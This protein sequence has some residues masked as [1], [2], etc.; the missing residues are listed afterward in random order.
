MEW[1][2]LA[3]SAVLVGVVLMGAAGCGKSKPALED[4]NGTP[5][6]YSV[7]VTGSWPSTQ[8]VDTPV[9][10][11]LRAENIGS[12]LPHLVIVFDGLTPTWKVLSAKGCGQKGIALQP[13]GADPGWDFG[14]MQKKQI[15]DF[16]F[17]VVAQTAAQSAANVYVRLFGAALN[18]KVGVKVPVNGGM[19]LIGNVIP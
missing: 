15:C 1:N 5:M 19:Q 8:E 13:L 16:V 9:D 10:L 18:G 17:H 11:A 14:A 3:R 4:L 6:P 12:A 7:V 2:A